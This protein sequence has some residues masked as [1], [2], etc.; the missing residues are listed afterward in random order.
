MSDHLNTRAGIF[1]IIAGTILITVN[2]SLVK[3][4]AEGYALHQIVLARSFGGT[5]IMLAFLPWV[6]G[7]SVL[8][9]DKP[10]AHTARALLLVIANMTFFVSLAVMPLAQVTALF[11]IAPM[12]IALL[13]VFFLGQPIGWHRSIAIAV[14]FMGVL[15]MLGADLWQDTGVG[16]ALCLPLIAALAYASMQVMTHSLGAKAHPVAMVVY[17]QACFVVVSFF[18]WVAAG[19]GRFVSDVMHPS[20]YFLLREWVWPAASDL[21]LF[22]ILGP[23]IASVAW[24]M[25]QAYRLGDPSAIAP[26]EYVALPFAVLWGYLFFGEIPSASLWLGMVLIAGAGIYVFWRERKSTETANTA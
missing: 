26:F 5:V 7:W 16:W 10:V 1:A 17:V 14:G 8:K 2:D 25:T 4:L 24:F 11:F 15:V 21:W 12:L 23:V 9:T 6:G 20:L 19:D 22:V 18:F 3:G 13:S